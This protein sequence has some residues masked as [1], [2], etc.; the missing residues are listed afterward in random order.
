[1]KSL[2]N[3]KRNR[4]ADKKIKAEIRKKNPNISHFDLNS[5]FIYESK[6]SYFYYNKLS[7]KNLMKPKDDTIN[8]LKLSINSLKEN[9][10]KDKKESTIKIPYPFW[11]YFEEMEKRPKIL[12]KREKAINELVSQGNKNLNISCRR[13]TQKY[14]ENFPDDH[15]SKSTVYRILTNK[16]EYCFR[17]TS[18]KNEVLLSKNSIRQVY[19]VLK[20]LLRCMKLNFEI[21]FLDESNFSTNNNNFKTWR[22]ENDLI[23]HKIKKI[24]KIN[25]LLAVSS[26]K[27]INY[28][29]T[30][31]NTNS[32]IFLQFMEELVVKIKPEEKKKYLIFMDNLSIHLTRSLFEFYQK[33]KLKILFNVPYLSPF[34]MVELCFRQMKRETYTHLYS[35]IE[36]LKND[37]S[38]I[39][40]SDKL[41]TELKYLYRETLEKYLI[42]INNY[43]DFNLN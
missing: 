41:R 2:I 39:L 42:F 40:S 12:S 4:S 18:I 43:K 11:E 32:K 20:I 26:N 34:N 35:S 25:L 19:F 14:N 10:K 6:L 37:I 13:I 16:L 30:S 15:I 29:M 33:E 21:I 5:S 24:D 22:H 8:L 31:E 38:S 9:E 1:M 3:E 17:K 36:E 23:Y 27:I 28:K 7:N